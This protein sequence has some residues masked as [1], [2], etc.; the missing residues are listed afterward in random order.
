M[1]S[2]IRL[3]VVAISGIINLILAVCLLP[4]HDLLFAED[5]GLRL[6]DSSPIY[7]AAS[8]KALDL[9]AEVTLEAWVK[10]EKMASAGGR[11]LDKTL[12]GT[13]VG[14]MLDTHPGNSLRLLNA[15][16]MCRYDA[17]LPADQWT[18][19]VGVFSA[20]KK[21]MK[22]YVNGREVARV[23]R[24][25]TPMTLSQVPL[26]IGADPTGD[27]RFHG[28]IRRAAIYSRALTSEEV[29]QRFQAAEP[30]P[31]SG[32]LGEWQLTGSPGARS[33]RSPVR[34]S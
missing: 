25:F 15:T 16:G 23:T 19:V 27:N 24:E 20:H 26:C 4:P 30:G 13:Q 29:L 12:P 8:Q 31:R 34:W 14:Y 22:L 11:I 1:T 33:H 32:V 2:G 28:R 17:Q 21:I 6:N 5:A 7:A 10:A 9:T 3:P 18:H